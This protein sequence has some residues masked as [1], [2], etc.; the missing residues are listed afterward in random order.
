MTTYRT[1][2]EIWNNIYIAVVALPKPVRRVC[3]VQI[4]AFM[5]WY[6]F[7]ASITAVTYLNLFKVSFLVLFVSNEERSFFLI[8]LIFHM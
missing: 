3:Y 6:V 8:V 2:R 4:F 5:G 1:F 7:D